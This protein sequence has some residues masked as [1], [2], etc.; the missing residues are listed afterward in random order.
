MQSKPGSLLFGRVTGRSRWN[1]ALVGVLFRKWSR[2]PGLG[3]E[4]VLQRG[5]TVDCVSPARVVSPQ[6]HPFQVPFITTT[7]ESCGPPS[8]KAPHQTTNS[9]TPVLRRTAGPDGSGLVCRYRPGCSLI[10]HIMSGG[11]TSLPVS[12]TC[13][14]NLAVQDNSCIYQF[15]EDI[16]STGAA[17]SVIGETGP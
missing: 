8:P 7:G 1:D 2:V 5:F 15:I 14:L 10:M 17:L 12:D 16:L 6:P 11:K 13:L 9:P 3:L 4:W